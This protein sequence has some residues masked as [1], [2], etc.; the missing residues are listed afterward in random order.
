M[1]LNRLSAY[2]EHPE[3]TGSVAEFNREAR[4]RSSPW[5]LATIGIVTLLLV[6]SPF[7]LLLFAGKHVSLVV[8]GLAAGGAGL[9]VGVLV[10]AILFL[11]IIVFAPERAEGRD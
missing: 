4:P 1:D 11:A 7:V 9:F 2:P 10:I 8:G 3:P 5:A 6:I